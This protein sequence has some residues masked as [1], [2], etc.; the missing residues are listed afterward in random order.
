MS[1]KIIL[2]TSSISFAKATRAHTG[3]I[4]Y[5]LDSK[6]VEYEEVDLATNK[7]R[8]EEMVKVSGGERAVPQ[9]HVDDKSYG[10]YESVQ[11]LEDAGELAAVL[12]GETPTPAAPPA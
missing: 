11:E 1:P 6:G 5:M 7:E 8:A 4:K 3:S 10:G 12:K 2:Y 9:L